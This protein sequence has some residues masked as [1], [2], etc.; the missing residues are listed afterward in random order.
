MRANVQTNCRICM[1][2][3]LQTTFARAAKSLCIA[4]PLGRNPGWDPF[5]PRC[6]AAARQNWCGT[7]EFAATVPPVAVGPF[8]LAAAPYSVAASPCPIQLERKFAGRQGVAS[9]KVRC[10]RGHCGVKPPDCS[11]GEQSVVDSA[12]SSQGSD[13]GC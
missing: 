1:M 3:H 7:L 13:G 8:S 11:Q 2:E 4:A 5:G 6:L 9:Q 10:H 12:P